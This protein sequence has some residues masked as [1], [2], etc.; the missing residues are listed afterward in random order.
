MLARRKLGAKPVE[1]TVSLLWSDVI[2][3]A[4]T[5]RKYRTGSGRGCVKTPDFSAKGAKCNSL[6]QRPR[7]EQLKIPSAESAKCA[8]RNMISTIFNAPFPFR[9]FSASRIHRT[10]TQ[11]VALGYYISRLW[12]WEPGATR[13]R[14][15][16]DQTHPL[17]K[18]QFA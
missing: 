16:G 18:D 1:Q 5:P 11:G 4:Q 7:W 2:Q 9:A 15:I 6:G 17:Q 10:P 12:R 13:R 8:G 3:R 14:V